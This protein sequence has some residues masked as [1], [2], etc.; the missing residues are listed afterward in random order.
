[1]ELM[2]SISCFSQL[3]SCENK[4]CEPIQRYITN[5]NEILK[6]LEPIVVEI[7]DVEVVASDEKL[8][9]TLIRTSQFLDGLREILENWQPL[10]SKFYMVL[11]AESLIAKIEAATLEIFELLESH[12]Q[13]FSLEEDVASLEHA[14]QKMM[15][16]QSEQTSEI[17]MKAIRDQFESSGASLS[18]LEKIADC[19]RLKSNQELLIE[20]V[21]LDKLKETSEQ[22]EMI[23]DVDYIDDL[24]SLVTHMHEQFVIQN[25]SRSCGP[26]TIPV[27]FCCPLSLE[28][29]TDPVI[30]SSG[31][32]YDRAFIQEWFDLGLDVCP[33]TRQPLGHATLVPN[34]I[35]KGFIAGWCL[36]NNVKFPD[37]KSG[38]LNQ[39][40]SL[41]E[42]VKSGSTKEADLLMHSRDDPSIS[43]D[44][45]RDLS[46]PVASS[47][48]TIE[49]QS[50]PSLIT[51]KES[52]PE[53]IGN[54]GHGIEIEEASLK[55]SDGSVDNSDDKNLSASS[56]PSLERD[57]SSSEDE[58]TS[59]GH[60]RTVSSSNEVSNLEILQG[61]SG[62]GNESF[63][64]MAK[65]ASD[66]V[67]SL[68][69]D[70]ENRNIQQREPEHPYG[71]EA[72]TRIPLWLKP[73]KRF[74][75]RIVTYSDTETTSDLSELETQ[76]NKL[77]E[78]LKSPSL[79]SQRKACAELRLLA[80][81]STENRIVIANCGA[82]SP[83][84][85]LLRSTDKE[86]QEIAVTALLNLSINDN[87]KTA[88]AYVDAIESLMHVLQTGTPEA[89]EN[90]AATLFSLSKVE[91]N[92]AKIGRSGAIKPLVDLLGNGTLRGKKDATTALFNLSILLENKIRIVEAGAVKYLV[93]LM[94]PAAGMVDKAV[95]VLSNLSTTDEGKQAI[96]T[97]DAIPVLVEVVELGSARGKENAAA[98]LLQLCASS[99]L[100]CNMALQEGVVPPL[101][102]LLHSGTSRAKE[103]AN[104]LLTL[105][106][107]RQNT[108]TDRGR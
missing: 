7:V 87:N 65:D 73:S 3:S 54:D 1:M 9:K 105:F 13:C 25:Q 29:M 96:G 90:S 30:V 35:V 52:F 93:D 16:I 6:I 80:R 45:A 74:V 98:T 79:D 76:V 24:I 103:K 81:H 15:L 42:S 92:R 66:Q 47:R 61:T 41:L 95:A 55:G 102:A 60:T 46:S 2:E 69:G 27:D 101:K 88:I 85:N 49:E 83:L 67:T 99:N 56:L 106:R 32:T 4:D 38:S 39:S 34:Y 107:S 33:K 43:L 26:V 37:P 8:Q 19:L 100:F 82:I 64:G 71:S 20:I 63:H 50:S 84:V 94:D 28:L 97:D 58:R 75:P 18:S 11:Q 36:S 59:Q 40:A 31:Q 53:L 86:I 23:R 104:Q 78:E 44:S 10:L 22:G 14:V 5:A 68:S 89:K 72:R 51:S 62:E 108:N 91:D 48:S 70:F 12:E 21:A 57:N 77:I 17:I